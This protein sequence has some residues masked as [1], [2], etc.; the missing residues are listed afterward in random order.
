MHAISANAAFATVQQAPRS[1]MVRIV[2]SVVA[3]MDRAKAR[4]EYRRLLGNE[5]IMRDIGVTRHDVRE[6]LA[7]SGGRL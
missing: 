7:K 1:V 4:H 3:A 5:A 6:A 2:A